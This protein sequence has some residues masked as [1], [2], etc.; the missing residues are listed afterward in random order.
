MRNYINK[1]PKKTQ[2]PKPKKEPS[3]I[4]FF[5]VSAV[6]II[7]LIGLN[8]LLAN[9]P[10]EALRA[11]IF[12]EDEPTQVYLLYRSFPSRD[13]AYAQSLLV[14]QSGAGGYIYQKDGEYRVI[15]SAYQKKEDAENVA[16]KNPQANLEAKKLDL[17]DQTANEIYL[18]LIELMD[19]A[20]QLEDGSIYEARLLEICSINRMKL[21][22]KKQ[23][24]IHEDGGS[25]LINVLE[26]VTGGL[27]SLNVPGY[28]RVT[29]LSDLRYIIISALMSLPS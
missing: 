12:K 28:S 24:L 19:G 18:A 10:Y 13:N 21:E 16:K 22:E 1:K 3:S 5:I 2:S 29:L 6:V 7:V 4:R 25:P 23:S 20:N 14:R 26:V 11:W 8:F 9:Q 17:K 15:Y 27:S